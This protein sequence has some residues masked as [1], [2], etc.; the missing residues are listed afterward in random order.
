MGERRRHPRYP[1]VAHLM[2]R[3]DPPIGQMTVEA[4]DVSESGFSFA[5]RE[6]L[7]VGDLIVLGLRND[8]Q[9][10]VEATVRNVREEGDHF[11]VGAERTSGADPPS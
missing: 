9:F 5:T 1:F 4:R 8:D 10:L 11:V 3:A 2:I 6:K 7:L